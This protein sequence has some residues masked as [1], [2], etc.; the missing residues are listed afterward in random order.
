MRDG[1]IKIGNINDIFK[2]GDRLQIV[3][4]HPKEH[5][6]ALFSIDNNGLISFYTNKVGYNDDD[7][8]DENDICS[9]PADS[10]VDISFPSSIVLDGTGGE[11]LIVILVSDRPIIAEDVRGVIR[12]LSKDDY[13]D[14]SKTENALRRD[15]L[16]PHTSVS[17]M[18][19]RKE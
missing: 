17:S 12:R 9:V 14:L 7:N 3:Y 8:T 18:R 1:E 6:A 19:I 15:G 16:D 13:S 5:H 2:E 4:S 11:E 10:G